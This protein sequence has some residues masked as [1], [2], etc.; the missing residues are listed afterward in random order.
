MRRR[1]VSNVNASF[2]HIITRARELAECNEILTFNM[3][4]FKKEAA[5]LKLQN[6]ELRETLS[7]KFRHVK[8]LEGGGRGDTVTPIANDELPVAISADA[9]T[10]DARIAQLESDILEL[11]VENASRKTKFDENA[12]VKESLETNV[13]T[14]QEQVDAL[15]TAWSLAASSASRSAGSGRVL[16]RTRRA[17]MGVHHPIVQRPLDLKPVKKLASLAPDTVDDLVSRF[18]DASTSS[19]A[20]R[21]N[22]FFRA[23]GR[24][25]WCNEPHSNGFLYAA[26]HQ[27]NVWEHGLRWNTKTRPLQV[28]YNQEMDL[29]I[30]DDRDTICL[31]RFISGVSQHDLA[32]NTLHL[33]GKVPDRRI[34]RAMVNN[35]LQPAKVTN[36]IFRTL[37]SFNRSTRLWTPISFKSPVSSRK[38][39][40]PQTLSLVSWNID[41]FSSQPLAR[42]KRILSHIL[43]GPKG[44]P[45][46]IFLQEVTTE[47]R[48]SILDDARVR[49]AFL[50]TDADDHTPFEG[51]PFATMTLLSRARCVFEGDG[52]DRSGK[53]MLG[54]VSRVALPSTSERDALCVDITPPSAPDTVKFRLVNVHLDPPRLGVALPS[55]RA[56]Q[57]KILVDILREPGCRG[58]IIAGDFVDALSLEEDWILEKTDVVDAWGAVHGREDA[59]GERQEGRLDKVAMMG[60]LQATEIEVVRPGPIESGAESGEIPWSDHCGLRCTFTIW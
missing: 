21:N 19:K 17:L 51:V 35:S 38:A 40:Q 31:C 22:L 4:L 30:L 33:Q 18:I 49:A 9:P 59:D 37:S 43:D 12:A 26:R 2:V 15:K 16:S 25:I 6:L 1:R 60:P 45:D 44:S 48:A 27:L 10:S 28:L 34:C 41:A 8:N 46:I 36:R 54:D 5:Q 39:H 11:K 20:R 55:Y 32:K 53:F 29:L 7:N 58:G 52:F 3:Q 57:I 24:I 42:S 13:R 23:P 14:L 56:W 47:V 50:V